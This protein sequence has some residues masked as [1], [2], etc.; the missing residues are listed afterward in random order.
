MSH[1]NFFIF[2]RV[3]LCVVILQLMEKSNPVQKLDNQVVELASGLEKVKVLLEQ[4]SPTVNEAQNA[5]KVCVVSI[6]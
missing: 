3:C 4:R 6:D 1:Q 2:L 5:L